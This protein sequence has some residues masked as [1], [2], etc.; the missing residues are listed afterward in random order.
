MRSTRLD[1]LAGSVRK[2]LL[3]LIAF[4]FCVYGLT[5]AD[6]LW[7]IDRWL[8]DRLVA[9]ASPEP[10][11]DVVI[12]AVDEYS[13]S[14][15]GRWPFSRRTHARLIDRLSAVGASA[16]AFDVLLSEPDSHD[17]EG[18]HILADAIRR[19]G[20]VVLP[21]VA[22]PERASGP[23]IEVLP[24]PDLSE[25]AAAH[26]HAVLRHD[27][28]GVVRGVFLCAGLGDPYWPHL[29]LAL[30]EAAGEREAD[31]VARRPADGGSSPYLWIGA[32]EVLIPYPS[33]FEDYP[34]I[35]YA[36]VLRGGSNVEL[37]RDRKVLVG[38]TAVGLGE[39]VLVSS[40][41]DTRRLAGVEY[42]AGVLDALS[43]RRTLRQASPG[44]RGGIGLVLVAMPF[45]L[46][47]L[48]MGRLSSAAVPILLVFLVVPGALC[49]YQLWVPPA[50]I[51]LPLL[52]L[53]VAWLSARFR[54]WQQL[55]R[56]DAM[57]GIANRRRFDQAL[58]REWRSQRR[59]GQPLSLLLIDV[60]HFKSY[61]DSYGHAE[62]DRVLAR[63]ARTLS[64]HAR[65]PRDLLARYGG[66]EFALI[67]PETDADGARG[68]AESM[69]RSVL[70]LAEPHDGNEVDGRVTV[71]IGLHTEQGA[72]FSDDEDPLNLVRRADAALYR[73]KSEGRNRVCTFT[74]EKDIPGGTASCR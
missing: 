12:V 13:L 41:A 54:L 57:T 58:L 20:R 45:V 49:G 52:G 55:A 5:A 73:A 1:L 8:F 48:G 39:S 51:L 60:D 69:R 30:L 16:I 6:T 47:G 7:Q 23:L 34:R 50:A 53:H 35:S 17:L 37:L 44:L 66:E 67:L 40:G 22:E 42:H 19:H 62:G 38:V 74:T 70:A 59:S 28:D 68:I 61:N 25:A 21:I 11:E 72:S 46:V 65:R 32:E 63:V 9:L 15:L 27:R 36:E 31:C 64:K 26:G 4:L 10:S 33:S 3:V 24:L 14:E 56:N 29:M 18:D 71:S 2:R 43:G